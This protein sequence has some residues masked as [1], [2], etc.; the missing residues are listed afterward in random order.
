MKNRILVS[1]LLLTLSTIRCA[2]ASS[3]DTTLSSVASF[4][5]ASRVLQHPRCTNCHPDGDSPT[6]GDEG[7]LHDPAVTRGSDGFGIPG[8]RCFSCHQDQNLPLAPV[9]GAPNWHLSARSMAW[10]GKS[11]REICLQLK[12]P[13]RNGGK[14]LQQIVDH[15]AHDPL[16]AW[17]WNP[18]WDRTTPPGTQAQLGESLATWVAGGA[19]CPGEERKR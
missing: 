1:V 6:Q 19:K 10:A 7:Y 13:L 9:P 12:D 16:V 5:K 11:S 8:M 15:A 4:L 2:T 3:T 14:T 18:G 17:A